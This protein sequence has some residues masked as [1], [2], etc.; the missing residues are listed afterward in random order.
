MQ[1]GAAAG[2]GSWGCALRVRFDAG[3]RLVGLAAQQVGLI[4]QGQ[5]ALLVAL[6]QPL[7][8]LQ[9]LQGCRLARPAQARDHRSAWLYLTHAFSFSAATYSPLAGA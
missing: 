3:V 6:A 8:L 5:R 7:L 4:G 9:L 1:D 2:R